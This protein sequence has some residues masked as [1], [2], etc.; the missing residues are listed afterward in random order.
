MGAQKTP[1]AI[2]KVSVTKTFDPAATKGAAGHVEDMLGKII[3][4][5]AKLELVRKFPKD[6]KGFEVSG[7]VR[8]LEFDTSAKVISAKLSVQVVLM[9]GRKLHAMLDG[10]GKV[11]GVNPAKIEPAVKDVLDAVAESLAAKARK[12][13][14]AKAGDL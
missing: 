1:V 13:M 9:P 4:G 8:E 11:D 7:T 6:A 10:G 3:K 14:E 2:D 5:S 12:A